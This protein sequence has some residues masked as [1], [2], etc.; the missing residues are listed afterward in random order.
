MPFERAAQG[1]STSLSVHRGHM[2][3][4]GGLPRAAVRARNKRS[5][6]KVTVRFEGVEQQQ[7]QVDQVR[8]DMG[9]VVGG[10]SKRKRR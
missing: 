2:H 5:R 9:A 3:V 6:R 8:E 4:K 10:R 1:P 7:F